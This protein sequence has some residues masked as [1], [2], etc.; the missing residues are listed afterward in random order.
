MRRCPLGPDDA[1]QI[2]GVDARCCPVRDRRRPR[3]ARTRV[4]GGVQRVPPS[5]S[6]RSTARARTGSSS[7]TRPTRRSTCPGW[8]LTDDPLDRSPLRADHRYLIPAAT[9][10][11]AGDELVVE[12]VASGF[13]FGISCGGDTIRLADGAAGSLIDEFAVPVLA[14][15]GDTW[16]RY[17]DGTGPW[18]E[19]APTKGSPNEPSAA[20]GG[21]A[22]RSVVALRSRGR[23]GHRPHAAPVDDRCAERHA[24]THGGLLRRDL[25]AHPGRWPDVRSARRRRATEGRPRVVPDPGRQGRVQGQVQPFGR[26]AAV[27]GPQEADPQQHGPG[28]VDDP[29][30]AGL[31]LVP[32][33]RRARAADGLR[34][35]A[36][37][38]RGLRAS[39]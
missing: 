36:R 4:R 18:V 31:R 24:R 28:Q 19:T 13:P 17:P 32:S 9:T 25:L 30:D 26:R 29:R 34:V 14:A 5:C 15:A 22:A 11:P 23:P 37:E 35:R 12:R 27:P 33:G 38:R 39:T 10:I 6:T 20:G 8:L 16:G 7:S 3:G 1:L 2:L 21:T